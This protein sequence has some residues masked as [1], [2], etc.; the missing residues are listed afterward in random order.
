[1]NMKKNNKKIKIAATLKYGIGTSEGLIVLV[2]I[3]MVLSVA[4]IG[5]CIAAIVWD[6]EYSWIVGITVG[7][8]IFVLFAKILNGT[9]KTKKIIE[10]WTKDAVLL[11]GECTCID[12]DYP[13]VRR[14]FIVISK[15]S[16][17]FK[18][19]DKWIE[20]RSNVYHMLF[21]KYIGMKIGILYSPKYDEV[22][23]PRY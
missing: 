17:R 7:T 5:L 3:A 13:M 22:M 21:N 9:I 12:K 19:N 18:Y 15:I 20:K 10:S 6:D 11:Q 14:G 16:V 1:M 4:M 8:C 2:I 23:I